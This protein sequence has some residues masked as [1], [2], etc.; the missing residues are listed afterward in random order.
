[1]SY[2]YSDLRAKEVIHI[3][4][5]ERL[6]FVSDLEIDSTGKITAINIAGAYRALGILGK[7]PDKSIPW[8]Y[9]KKI[10][11]DLIIIDKMK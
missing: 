6:G 10:G 1:M 2:K 4:D 3:T 8:E 11:D 7:E 5:G 9:I